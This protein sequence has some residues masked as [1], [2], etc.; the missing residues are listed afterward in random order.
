MIGWIALRTARRALRGSK[1]NE[2]PKEPALKW[3][4]ITSD[5]MGKLA[6]VIFGALFVGM[7]VL[8]MWFIDYSN[9]RY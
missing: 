5:S 6:V 1:R 2:R 9:T 4:E 3:S 7:G 8:I